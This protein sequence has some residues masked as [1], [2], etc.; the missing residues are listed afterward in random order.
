MVRINWIEF[1]NLETGLKCKRINFNDDITLLVGVSGAGKTQIIK[2]IKSLCEFASMRHYNTKEFDGL[3]AKMSFMINENNYIWKIE[4]NT[5]K[6]CL[7]SHTDLQFES[8]ENNYRLGKIK[9]ENL[10]CNGEEIFTRNNDSIN[11]VKYGDLP[12]SDTETSL[13]FQYR[14]DEQLHEVSMHMAKLYQ[15]YNSTSYEESDE[16]PLQYLKKITKSPLFEGLKNCKSNKFYLSHFPSSWTIVLKTYLLKETN[17]SIFERIVDLYQE[18]F[19]DITNIK[20]CKCKKTDN[21]TISFET[22]K[23]SIE[24]KNMSSGMQKT[25]A[26]LLDLFTVSPDYVFLMDE[27]ENS[28]G[29]NCIDSVYNCLYS[30]RDDLQ[31]IITSHHPYIINNV[32]PLQCQLVHRKDNIVEAY[33]TEQLKIS[34]DYYEFFDALLN[35]MQSGDI[36]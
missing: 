15:F 7:K 24:F 29:I 5:I 11:F 34:T 1:E 16:V 30:Y 14:R 13:I 6:D 19:P 32:N 2:T 23:T 26:F 12:A 10:T 25:F 17:P 4:T 36:P 9:Y 35:K 33:T 3:K 22:K 27:I 31:F 18:S 8:F 20:V 21:Y 28:L